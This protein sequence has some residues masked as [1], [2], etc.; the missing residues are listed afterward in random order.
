M[1]TNYKEMKRIDWRQTTEGLIKIIIKEKIGTKQGSYYL[2]TLV[3]K[4]IFLFSPQLEVHNKRCSWDVI[5][6]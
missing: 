6:P 2:K 3:N 1:Y 4:S 5:A